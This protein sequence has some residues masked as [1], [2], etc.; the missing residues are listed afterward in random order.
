MPGGSLTLYLT[1][2]IVED[3][4][5]V[6]ARCETCETHYKSNYIGKHCKNDGGLIKKNYSRN[7][8]L[9]KYRELLILRQ[10]LRFGKE[11]IDYSWSSGFSGF[12]E[13]GSRNCKLPSK[14]DINELEIKA[15]EIGIE[16]K[17]GSL[18]ELIV[19]SSET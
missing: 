18:W 13:D 14:D 15:K 7:K 3:P 2:K 9:K 8:I 12:E 1:R 6:Y 19:E 10:P 17:K 4:R 11:L 5:K 16:F